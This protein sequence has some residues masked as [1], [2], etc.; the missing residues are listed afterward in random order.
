MEEENKQKYEYFTRYSIY[1]RPN[2]V[3][4]ENS[5]L[6]CARVMYG[7]QQYIIYYIYIYKCVM[8]YVM[9][10]YYIY[11][12][13]HARST[14]IYSRPAG[15]CREAPENGYDTPPSF[16]IRVKNIV[17]HFFRPRRRM[18]TYLPTCP[19]NN[20]NNISYTSD[21]NSWIFRRSREN[22][23]NRPIENNTAV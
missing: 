13:M 9:V 23:K 16:K 14:H 2:S 8:Y 22:K 11:T 10:L 7:R 19:R 12:R 3:Y 1:R 4:S 20:N 18:Y 15:T 6:P 21:G 17:Y 5:K